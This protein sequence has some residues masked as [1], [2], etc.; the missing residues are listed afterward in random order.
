MHKDLLYD[1]GSQPGSGVWVHQAAGMD[2]Q[3]GLH[4]PRIMQLKGKKL[5][6]PLA[7]RSEHWVHCL[8]TYSLENLSVSS[9]HCEWLVC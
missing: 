6:E 3:F 5:S 2:L 8:D 1:C 7:V 4:G 9:S